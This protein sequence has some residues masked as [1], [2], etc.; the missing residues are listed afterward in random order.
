MKR[1][2]YMKRHQ[3]MRSRNP[4]RRRA[5]RARQFGDLSDWVVALPCHNCGRVFG[6]APAHVM[7]RRRGGAWVELPDGT[8]A[9]NLLPLCDDPFL[10]GCHNL[11]HLQ[12]WGALESIGS[13]GRAKELAALYGLAFLGLGQVPT[14]ETRP[15]A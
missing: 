8:E 14:S 5:D 13:L 12:G 10:P 2:A 6:I 15:P 9:G 11:Q 3:P 4:R 1:K 7:G